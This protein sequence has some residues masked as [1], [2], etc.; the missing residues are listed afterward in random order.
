MKSRIEQ[1]KMLHR[2]WKFDCE[3]T[4][5]GLYIFKKTIGDIKISWDI[6]NQVG[7]YTVG[8]SLTMMILSWGVLENLMK[9]HLQ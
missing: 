1:K 6:R 7:E 3:Q 4:K 5:E 8:E 2:K 9:Q